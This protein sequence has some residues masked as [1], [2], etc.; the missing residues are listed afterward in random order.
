MLSCGVFLTWFRKMS[1]KCVS[2]NTWEGKHN[3]EN[4][5]S[6]L[7]ARWF[8]VRQAIYQHA[9][10]GVVLQDRRRSS[11]TYCC[12]ACLTL[13]CDLS[14]ASS[15]NNTAQQPLI[16]DAL[17]ATSC[18]YNSCN[19]SGWKLRFMVNSE[20]HLELIVF[21]EIDSSSD[22]M[23]THVANVM[24]AVSSFLSRKDTLALFGRLP[25][26]PGFMVVLSSHLQCMFCVGVYSSYDGIKDSCCRCDGDPF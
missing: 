1:C 15:I 25:L 21:A 17:L 19:A 14:E 7:S 11:Y 12:I 26:G 5:L 9:I 16:L 10:S 20:S 18:C 6:Q 13:R 4:E 8:H 23:K 3:E 24:A 2:C 22:Y